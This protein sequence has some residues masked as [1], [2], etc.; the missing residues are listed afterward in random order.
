MWSFVLGI[1]GNLIAS[2][3]EVGFRWLWRS[4]QIERIAEIRWKLSADVWWLACDLHTIKLQPMLHHPDRVPDAIS[5]ALKHAQAI[6]AD[7]DAISS[8]Q[9]LSEIN[10]TDAT[11]LQQEVD[12]IINYFAKL[13]EVNQPDF[14]P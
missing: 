6:G 5:Q 2:A 7:Q 11:K 10:P 14:N 4:G 12:P 13:A 9:T 3:I 8:I 1:V